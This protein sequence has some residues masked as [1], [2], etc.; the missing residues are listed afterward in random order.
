[1]RYIAAVLLLMISFGFFAF[2]G[3]GKSPE[4]DVDYNQ[5]KETPPPE[6]SGPDAKRAPG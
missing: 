2:T 5:L 4:G 6:N 3:C 1:M